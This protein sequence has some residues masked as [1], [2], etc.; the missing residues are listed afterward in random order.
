[1]SADQLSVPAVSRRAILLDAY[2]ARSCPVK[3]QNTYD[4]TVQTLPGPVDESLQE[5]FDG[6]TAFETDVLDRLV[7][8]CTGAVIDLRELAGEPWP[9][10]VAACRQ[11]M[12]TGPMVII[13]G[14]LPA[15]EVGHRRGLADVWIR[16]GDQADGRPGYRA[17]E[18]KWHKVQDRATRATAAARA[19][20]TGGPGARSATPG[21]T[22]S[23]LA[24]SGLD[25]PTLDAAETRPDLR[26][27]FSRREAD[28]LQ[29]CHYHRLLEAA[30][31]AAPGPAMGGVIGTDLRDGE[32]VVTWV[33]LTEPAIR[34]FSR[35]AEAGFA[36]RSP[37]ERY[38]HEHD[39]RILVARTAVQQDRLDP[40]AL[41]VAPIVI[42]ECQRCPWFEQCRGQLHD[43]DL[44]LRIDKGPLDV[45]EI[46]VLRQ[47]GVQTLTDLVDVD[48]DDLLPRY[49]AE[50]THRPTARDRLLGARRRAAMIVHGIEIDRITH[51][52]I[53][54]PA[55]DTEVD[56]DLEASTD[57]RI[58]LWGFLVDRPG[59]EPSYVAFTRWHDLDA[60]EEGNL[61]VEALTWLRAQ[62]EAGPVRIYHYSGYER[63]Q[64]ERL[65]AVHGHPVLRWT[66]DHF[67][68]L[69]VDLYEVVR[70][71]WF[72]AHG[73]G[74][75]QIA[76]IGAGF[77]WR[78]EDPGG[79]NSQGWFEDAV[80]AG[81]DAAREQAR[82]RV[83]EYNEDD[84]FA[85]WAVRRWLRAAT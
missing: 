78:D 46:S 21:P 18:V 79:L 64:I 14:A 28:L 22:V 3:T 8:S 11:A 65:A 7:R 67:D 29:V 45:R 52:P 42:D 69:F 61:A 41:R 15:D 26:F 30:G 16:G 13:A 23:G 10:R 60:A 58:Y 71:H 9:V 31:W 80:H 24:V 47:L 82:R 4:P 33:S 40:P 63:V 66:L 51:G 32:P 6:G 25:H 19:A 44:S 39:F 12:A 81:T 70:Q 54:V 48:L 37:L 43:D 62:A 72:G 76:R 5:L 77:A 75:K 74:L 73:L 50:V 2:A 83:L 53:P 49:L 56:F 20:A 1:M 85:T 17:V 57:S 35:S 55:A 36:L 27:R 59:S 84:V 38:D 34:T 68:E